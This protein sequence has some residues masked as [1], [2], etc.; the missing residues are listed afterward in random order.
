MVGGPDCANE[1]VGQWAEA[2]RFEALDDVVRSRLTQKC[3]RDGRE[4]V[5]GALHT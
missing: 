4:E 3:G 2:G 5:Q 1:P